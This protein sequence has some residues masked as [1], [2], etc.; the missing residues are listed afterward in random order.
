MDLTFSATTSP[1]QHSTIIVTATNMKD[2][3]TPI[4]TSAEVKSL[5]L[6]R[7]GSMNDAETNSGPLPQMILKDQK[8]R[9]VSQTE[10]DSPDEEYAEQRS[11]QP[12]KCR[13]KMTMVGPF[14]RDFTSTNFGLKCFTLRAGIEV[15]ARSSFGSR[16]S[17]F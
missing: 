14:R 8:R 15:F 1:F 4:Q 6:R 10:T 5:Q 11:F 3:E 12:S 16:S 9:L 17:H 7:C 2:A 13:K